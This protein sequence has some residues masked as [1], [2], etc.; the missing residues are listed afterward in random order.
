MA[1]SQLGDR[2]LVL[3]RRIGPERPADEAFEKNTS[4]EIPEKLALG[5]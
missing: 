4:M 2:S 1:L 5:Q 3:S